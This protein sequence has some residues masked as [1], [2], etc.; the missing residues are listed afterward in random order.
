MSIAVAFV[1]TF[2]SYY[3]TQASAAPSPLMLANIYY[4]ST[5][6]SDTNTCTQ[7]APCKTIK[8][9]MSVAQNGDT[10][11]VS[12]GVYHEYVYVDKSL[13]IISNGAIVDGTNA[14]G[15]IT[16]G[17][18][19]VFA[20]NV[21]LQGF[22]IANAKD[23]G[24]ANFGSNNLFANNIIH[25]TQGPAIWM[26]DGKF[27]TFEGNE[28][29][30]SVLQNS[31]SFDG[32]HYVCN[33]TVT[34]WPSAIN[35]WGA[36]SSNIWRN[37]NIHDNCGEGIV[38]ITGD[39]VE[40]N[41]FKNNWSVE[42]YIANNGAV[43]RNNTIIDTKPYTPRGSDQSWRNVPA[44]IS[45]GDEVTCL[46]DNSTITGNS[47]AGARYGISFYSYMA[48]SGIKNSLIENNTITNAWEY[49]LRILAGAHTNS[50]I[51]NNKIQLTSGKPLTIQNN[52]FTI[53]G[54]ILFSNVNVIEWIGKSYDF[55]GWNNLVAGNFW[56]A[57]GA[58]TATNTPV[59][60]VTVR[61]TNT[62][63]STAQVTPTTTALLATATLLMPT[64]TKI[65]PT[66]TVLPSF[67][68]T[69]LPTASSTPIIPTSTKIT[70]ATAMPQP[71]NTVV[72][73]SGAT[74]VDV[75]VSS[76]NDDVEESSSG[77]MTINSSDLELVYDNSAQFV[78]IRFVGVKIPQG[79]VITNAYI[80][81]KVDETSGKTINL[82][83]NGEASANASS[84]SRTLRNVSGRQRTSN[85]VIW[86]PLAW[87]RMGEMGVAEQTPN[88]AP[89]IQEIVS[90]STWVSGNSMVM[91]ISGS[92]KRTA[93]SYEIDHRGAPLLHIEYIM[94]ASMLIAPT[95]TVTATPTASP[96]TTPTMPFTVTPTVPVTVISPTSTIVPVTP[97]P[98]STDTPSATETA[99]ATQTEVPTEVP[100]ET[101]P[102]P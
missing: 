95:L 79:A 35:S 40:N 77:A 82:T 87:S 51:R 102:A 32:A 20:N 86:S 75:Q 98:G 12:A 89:I 101:P 37:N 10:L 38:T 83:I 36:A 76:G 78:G 69:K 45:I 80:Q 31:V 47:I 72:V 49:G 44:G 68:A 99:P 53:T 60:T 13:T 11:M 90:Q 26:R 55:A 24:L 81:F 2:T 22:T 29:Y 92:G 21:K 25:N 15:T 52:G 85:S 50:I 91:I 57:T 74:S 61:A 3:Q 42:I 97:T 67:T 84:F 1:L 93:R 18:V 30:D 56:G 16:D 58:V 63:A 7:S 59:P 5:A 9:G 34:A 17:L 27:N 94:P 71:T 96:T 46:S 66:I 33:P 54:N 41:T 48:C 39:L 28:L 70:T 73:S 64:S 43:V 65:L 19:S 88:L 62:P 6:G 100:T 4:V 23:Y 8:K 14:S